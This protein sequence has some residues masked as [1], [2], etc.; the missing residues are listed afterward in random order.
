MAADDRHGV[1]AFSALTPALVAIKYHWLINGALAAWHRGRAKAASAKTA[2]NNDNNGCQR[3]S[4]GRRLLQPYSGIGGGALKAEK[5]QAQC[6]T[7]NGGVS[8]ARA[9]RVK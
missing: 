6:R 9:A 4:A 2:G 8:A 1:G 5:R 3:L 7:I